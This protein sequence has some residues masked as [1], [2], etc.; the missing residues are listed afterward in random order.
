MEEINPDPVAV[1]LAMAEQHQFEQLKM[2][3]LEFVAAPEDL[4][5]TESSGALF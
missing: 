2:A 5:G 1:T 3:C 4:G